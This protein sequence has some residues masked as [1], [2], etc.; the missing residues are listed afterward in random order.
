MGFAISDYDYVRYTHRKVLSNFE[1]QTDEE[2]HHTIE[3]WDPDEY[4]LKAMGLPIQGDCE[5]FARACLLAIEKR[6]GI[7]VRLIYC[8]DE[9]GQ[10][11]CVCEAA[12]KDRQEA[13]IL[14]NRKT[15]ICTTTQL[16]GYKFIAAGP[17]NPIPQETRPWEL[18]TT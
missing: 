4:V 16:K 9:T 15:S 2:K 18:L 1:Y 5:E 14:D 10:G 8:I 12:S 3:Y 6:S 7:D 17:W 11:H 13:Y